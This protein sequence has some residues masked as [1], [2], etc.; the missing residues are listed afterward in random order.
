MEIEGVSKRWEEYVR[1]LFEDRSRLHIPMT[2]PELLDEEMISVINKF[3]IIPCITSFS[4]I[5]SMNF[6][7]R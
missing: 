2:G 7:V 6:E 5:P 1:D 3:Y 4:T